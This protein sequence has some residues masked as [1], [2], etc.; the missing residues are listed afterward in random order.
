L[1]GAFSSGTHLLGTR[2]HARLSENAVITLHIDPSATGRAA[3][4]SAVLG[5]TR[6]FPFLAFSLFIDTV[7]N[8]IPNTISNTIYV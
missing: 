3:R 5:R 1:G 8:T 2:R 6:H 7:P 4:D